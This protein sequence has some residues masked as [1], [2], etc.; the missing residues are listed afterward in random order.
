MAR[1]D[2]EDSE[3][4]RQMKAWGHAQKFRW[5]CAPLDDNG[6]AD[7]QR[8]HILA[9]NQNLAPKTRERADRKLIPRSGISRRMQ[10]AAAANAICCKGGRLHAGCD[11]CPSRPRA[12]VLDVAP[13]WSCDPIPAKNDASHPFDRE[14]ARVDMGVP[15]DLRWIDVAMSQMARQYPLREMCVREEY[16]GSGSQGA[17][18]A[19]VA[20]KYGGKLSIWMYRREIQKGLEFLD[21][22][23]AA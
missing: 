9:K 5:G 7:R 13:M 11:E 4:I 20:Q 6:L 10:M 21:V 23:R 16:A 22:R 8:A 3:L 19:R 18:F 15:E 14:P 2:D 1:R 12:P 17:K